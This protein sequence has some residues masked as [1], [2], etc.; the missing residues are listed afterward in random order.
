METDCMG[1]RQD[2][3]STQWNGKA[4][5]IKGNWDRSDN[6]V[7]LDRMQHQTSIPAVSEC[8]EFLFTCKQKLSK[9]LIAR[10][11]LN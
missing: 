4:Q 2:G 3:K 1:Q 7:E 11:T 8:I 5:I 6:W 9:K 10:E